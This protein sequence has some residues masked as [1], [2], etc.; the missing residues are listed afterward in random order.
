MIQMEQEK[1]DLQLNM[2]P[3]IDM[4]FLL[5]IF[6]LTATTFT[7]KEREQDV[8]LPNN[9]NPGSLSRNLDNNI[10]I[11]VKQDGA[12]FVMGKKVESEQLVAMLR[13]RNAAMKKQNSK[14]KVMVRGDRRALVEAEH[15]ALE[16]AE[17]AGISKIF[18]V[19]K[20]L[21]IE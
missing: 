1:E 17:K 3:M 21:E 11:N 7:E 4:I 15:K 8:L 19:T 14:L 16:A 20:I 10:I 13:E 12:L 18:L 6:F 5:I 2:A 9:K